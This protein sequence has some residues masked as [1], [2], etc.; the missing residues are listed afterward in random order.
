MDV[1][2]TWRDNQT[3]GIDRL[4][5]LARNGVDNFTVGDPEVGDFVT[6]VGRV[7]DAAVGDT[8]NFFHGLT[9]EN[10]EGRQVGFEKEEDAMACGFIGRTH[11][12][13][14]LL[15]SVL[16]VSSVVNSL[17]LAFIA[18]RRLLRRRSRGRPCGRR[19]RW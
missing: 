3:G 10:T 15:L 4:G 16:S 19:C 17:G 6:V 13:G 18:A 8:G 12:I 7:N 9:T 14:K 1:D 5:F 11:W 2:E